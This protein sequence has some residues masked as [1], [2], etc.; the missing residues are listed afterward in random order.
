[1]TE[2]W[3]E[4]EGQP[5]A[6]A[7]E[8][9]LLGALLTDDGLY[10]A[11]RAIVGPEHFWFGPHRELFR[12]IGDIRAGGGRADVLSVGA[13]L[14]PG[15]LASLP[16]GRRYLGELLAGVLSI[17]AAPDYAAT[18]RE[19]AA[20]RQL[21]DLAL[22]LMQ[23]LRDDRERPAAALAADLQGA[24]EQIVI[25]GGAG[26][27]RTRR[28]VLEQIVEGWSRPLEA[29]STGLATL[30]DRMVGG[31]HVQRCYGFLAL[32]KR[33]KT[34]LASTMSAALTAAGV[35]HAYVAMEMGSEQIELR[36]AARELGLSAMALLRQHGDRELGIRLGLLAAEAGDGTVYLDMAG[37]TRQEVLAEV[38][39]ARTKHG[40]RGWILDG[41]QLVQ[42]RDR[43]GN[44]EEHLRG[45]AQAVADHTKRRHLFAVIMGQLN[46]D[47]SGFGS[48]RG[49]NMACD[50]VWVLHRE[51]DQEYAW[52]EMQASR[53]TPLKH[54]GSDTCRPL[55]L[56]PRGPYFRDTSAQDS[57]A[58]F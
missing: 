44:L 58:L 35:K 49:L 10:D 31:L 21:S 41:W 19:L 6:Q 33:G 36:Q 28:Q 24:L 17:R 8:A 34:T 37:A 53:Y 52:L 43:R 25:S 48:R 22:G 29:Y 15:L 46:D 50:Q 30:D 9:A 14:G 56:E 42:G 4:T 16:D 38:D 47:G 45:T 18:V 40:I 11:C 39:A 5:V 55:K 20:R 2:H 7:A 12:I 13:R 27:V 1:M 23:A 3:Q 57:E 32:D 51:P 54:V 26:R